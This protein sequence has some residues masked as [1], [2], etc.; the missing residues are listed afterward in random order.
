MLHVQAE[1]R[2]RGTLAIGNIRVRYLL[3]RLAYAAF[4]VWAALTIVFVLL[5]LSGDPALSLAP[6]TATDEQVEQLREQLGFN[7]PFIV[8]YLRFI[9]Q[10]FQ[11]AF[12]SSL[13]SN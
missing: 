11:G 5:H 1:R 2:R 4:A 3:V 12:P 13:Y 7:D 10:V 9:G 6:E 8:Q